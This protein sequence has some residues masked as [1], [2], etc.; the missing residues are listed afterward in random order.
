[1]EGEGDEL[2][3]HLYDAWGGPIG[4]HGV[5]RARRDETQKERARQGDKTPMW[6]G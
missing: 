3:G 2:G 6:Q 5:E 1:M 4:M